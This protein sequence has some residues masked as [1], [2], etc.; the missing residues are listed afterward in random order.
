M[1]AASIVQQHNIMICTTA[2]SRQQFQVSSCFH[3]EA[4]RSYHRSSQSIMENSRILRVRSQKERTKELTARKQYRHQATG[5]R[6]QATGKAHEE[7]IPS[8]SKA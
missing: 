3:K 4:T 5:D 1:A 2:D 8:R 6:R 7:R